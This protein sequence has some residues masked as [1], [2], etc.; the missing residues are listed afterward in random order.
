MRKA[1]SYLGGHTLVPW[2]WF[3]KAKGP[4]RQPRADKAK[5]DPQR[6][7]LVVAWRSASGKRKKQLFN[8]IL[9]YDRRHRRSGNG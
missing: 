4:K 5:H 2:S 6:N 1:E 8:V 3:R 7:A 9:Q